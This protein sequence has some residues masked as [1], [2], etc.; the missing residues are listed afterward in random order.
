MLHVVDAFRDAR[1]EQHADAAGL[2]LRR[3]RQRLPR[4]LGAVEVR[5]LPVPVSRRRQHRALQILADVEEADA[6]FA[7]QPLV[8]AGRG[9]VDAERLARRAA[10][11]RPPG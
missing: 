4:Q 6:A 5:H 10:R 1:G 8:G 7:H 9:E 2:V 3:A 11:R